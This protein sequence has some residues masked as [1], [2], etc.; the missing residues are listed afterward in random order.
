LQYF[1]DYIISNWE[2]LLA[3]IYLLIAI[4]FITMMIARTTNIVVFYLSKEWIIL[5]NELWLFC[6]V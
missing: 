4:S 2:E 1:Y 3:T 6:I 5:K